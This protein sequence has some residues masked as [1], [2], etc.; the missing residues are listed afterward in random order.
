MS[1]TRQAYVIASLAVSLDGRIASA[2]RE[3]GALGSRAD[4]DRLDA[5]R[6]EADALV[7]GA[8]TIRDEDPPLAV[9]NPLRRRARRQAG[10][11]ETP[12]VVVVSRSG[13]LPADARFLQEDAPERWLAVPDGLAED[14]IEALAPVT[15]AGRLRLQRLGRESVEPP[16]L[17]EALEARGLRRVLVEG[18]GTL[19][20]AFLDAGCIDELRLTVCPTLLGGA[21]APSLYPGPAR[22]LADRHR[23][24][25]LGMAC[26]GDEVY[27]RLAPLA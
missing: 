7:V 3:K 14:A 8:G 5:F 15:A 16:L 11:P 18:G 1:T 10:R 20:A 19:L 22:A 21:A 17:I 2:F 12:L 27:L 6:A 25:L 13:A 26:H 24:R 9:R 4:R 23:L